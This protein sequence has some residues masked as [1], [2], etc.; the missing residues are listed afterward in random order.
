MRLLQF[1][2]G[3]WGA[4][5]TF[6]LRGFGHTVEVYDV[7]CNWWN[8][9][10]CMQD[11]VDAVIVTTSSES[12]WP[13][14]KRSMELGIPVFVEKPA[15]LKRSQ[16]EELKKVESQ[17]L[18]MVGHQYLFQPELAHLKGTCVYM[19]S[20]RSGSVCRREGVL[21]NLMVHDIAIALYVMNIEWLE[22]VK[23]EGDN[24]ELKVTLS[25]NGKIV[26]LYAVENPKIKL[27]HITMLNK[28]LEIVQ[29]TPKD[30]TRTNLLEMEL[31]A[32]SAY[33]SKSFPIRYN[34]TTQAIKVME[35]V[36]KI[37]ESL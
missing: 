8:L 31:N 17:K 20:L 27:K 15:L 10:E 22:V 13:I 36:L 37:E 28:E 5:H 32:F 4:N 26:D 35:T 3:R 18:M 2:E 14:S 34:G 12:H 30:W 29:I 7:D 24:H 21:F 6:I 19:N 11:Q 23:A 16:L 1:G 9:L 25:H 33:V